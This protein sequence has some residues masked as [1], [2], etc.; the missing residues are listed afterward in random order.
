LT[1][2]PRERPEPSTVDDDGTGDGIRVLNVVT[3]DESR[4]FRQQVAALEDLGV[5]QT[6]V[7]VPGDRLRDGG[8]VESRS[9]VDY[10][11][12][13]PSVVRRSFGEYDLVHANYGLTAPAAL[14][15]PSLP[16]VVSLWGTDLMGKYGW[17]T[18]ACARLADAVVV[19]SPEMASILGRE[20]HVIPH[21][22]DFDRFAPRPRVEARDDLGWD[23]D[24]RY[25]LFPYP[26][27][28]AVKDYPRAK[29]VVEAARRRLGADVELVTITG[30]AHER[31]STYYNAADLLLLTSRREGSPNA[32]KEALAC[33]RPVVSTDVG[34]VRERVAGVANAHVCQTDEELVEALVG[35]L[36]ERG[37]S[38]GREAVRDCS[39][40]AMTARLLDV[41]RAVLRE[42]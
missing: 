21:G 6:T 40:E 10:A 13:L 3:N 15:Q 25:V 17:V 4:V 14:A 38:D 42:Q 34:D 30:V 27:G 9:V 8:A 7:T 5:R 11:R 37:E 20:C 2:R 33:N 41:Y 24:R 16:V 32:V 36:T 18:A 39:V 12:L 35:I 29:S 23:H 1:G 26:T 22:I 28:R 31:M 19:M